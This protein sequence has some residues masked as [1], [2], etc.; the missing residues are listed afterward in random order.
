MQEAVENEKENLIENIA[1]ADDELV[2][3]YLEGEALTQQELA[4]ALRKGTLA[5]IFVPVV[6]GSATRNIGIDLL[7]DLIVD[8]LPSPADQ[9][10]KT[11]VDLP[12]EKRLNEHRIRRH[13]FPDLWSKPWQIPMPGA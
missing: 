13:H 7:M 9:G 4:A 1:E 11:G 3:R 6:C 12:P 10:A 5:R 8:A 2:E